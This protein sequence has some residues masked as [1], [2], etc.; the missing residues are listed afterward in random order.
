MKHEGGGSPACLPPIPVHKG[1]KI[2]LTKSREPLLWRDRTIIHGQRHKLFYKGTNLILVILSCREDG[3]SSLEL[4]FFLAIIKSDLLTSLSEASGDPSHEIRFLIRAHGCVYHKTMA[5]AIWIIRKTLQKNHMSVHS[6]H[7]I[8]PVCLKHNVIALTKCLV[9]KI[10]ILCCFFGQLIS[11]MLFSPLRCLFWKLRSDRPVLCVSAGGFGG[12]MASC[13]R[14]TCH[15]P[16]SLLT[17]LQQ[18]AVCVRNKQPYLWTHRWSR[19]LITV[20]Y[21]C[22]AP[23]FGCSLH[24]DEHVGRDNGI[25]S[26]KHR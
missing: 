21:C 16:S 5:N 6:V 3:V 17:L 8:L 10:A 14:Q 2:C 12:N 26:L 20:T 1:P 22:K 9:K 11:I 23:L 25:D 19:W 4:D 18:A 7:L 13:L 24:N 15:P